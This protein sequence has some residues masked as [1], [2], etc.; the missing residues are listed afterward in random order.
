MTDPDEVERLVR[1][2]PWATFVS[3]TA[4]GLVASHYPV[5]LDEAEDGIVLLSHFGRPDEQL[6]ARA[7]RDARHRAGAA[8]L[9][10]VELVRRG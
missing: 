8:R 3:A 5:I 7:A 10:V 4:Q 1:N 9:R 2:H 6:R